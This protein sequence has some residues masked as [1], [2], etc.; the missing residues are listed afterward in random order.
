MIW[1]T[2]VIWEP[3][4]IYEMQVSTGSIWELAAEEAIGTGK[5]NALFNGDIMFV[6]VWSKPTELL[7]LALVASGL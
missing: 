6:I 2:V 1:L 7:I 4:F 3:R 5:I